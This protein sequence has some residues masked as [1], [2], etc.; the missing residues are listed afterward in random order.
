MIKQERSFRGGGA[1]RHELDEKLGVSGYVQ[2]ATRND[3]WYYGNWANP[4]THTLISFAEGDLTE[5]RCCCEIEFAAELRRVAEWYDERKEWIGIDTLNPERI[6]AF[7]RLGLGDLI[8]RG[9]QPEA[10][11]EGAGAAA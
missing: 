11:A 2:L 9:S 5:S 3:A 4:A 8:A 10:S 6:A 1:S 7:E